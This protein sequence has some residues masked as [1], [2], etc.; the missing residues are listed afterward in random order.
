[1]AAFEMLEKPIA[2]HNYPVF[3]NEHKIG[4]VTSGTF[5]PSLK[6]PIGM[7]YVNTEYANIGEVIEVLIRDKRYK[8]QIVSMPFVKKK[9]V[10]S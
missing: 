6:K 9:M 10:N 3:K 4:S 5:S 1:L 7:A 2:R 8:A